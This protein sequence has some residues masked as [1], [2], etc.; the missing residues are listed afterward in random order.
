MKFNSILAI[1]TT[2]V[3]STKVHAAADKEATASCAKACEVAAEVQRQD[4]N[5]VCLKFAEQGIPF[6]PAIATPVVTAVVTVSANTVTATV[7]SGS[8]ASPAASSAAAAAAAASKSLDAQSQLE[9]K[10]KAQD[11]N[12]SEDR[13]KNASAS[14]SDD[15]SSGADK[16]VVGMGVVAIVALGY[17]F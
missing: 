4:C 10:G 15:M 5:T 14:A 2:T 9:N 1:I 12:N 13:A 3:L 6:L 8:S 16:T 17:L 11:E 7:K